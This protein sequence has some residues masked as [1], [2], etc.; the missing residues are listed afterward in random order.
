MNLLFAIGGSVFF[1]IFLAV[2]FSLGSGKKRPD[3]SNFAQKFTGTLFVLII[4]VIISTVF[5]MAG[6]NSDEEPNYPMKYERY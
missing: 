5:E 1:A 2:I 6:C 3:S 4:I